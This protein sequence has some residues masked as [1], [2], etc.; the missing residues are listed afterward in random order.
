MATA[1]PVAQGPRRAPS[2][3]RSPWQLAAARVRRDRVA[4]VALGF[5]VLLVLAVSAGAPLAAH[6]LGHGPN[7][8]FPYAV[9]INAKP[10][11]QWTWA[12]NFNSVQQP[13]AQLPA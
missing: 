1:A 4:L 6:L 11:G 3:P 5:L 12:P 9:N 10:V 8:P 7:D 13:G 2:Q